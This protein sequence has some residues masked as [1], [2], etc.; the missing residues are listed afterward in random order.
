MLC[1]PLDIGFLCLEYLGQHE[2]LYRWLPIAQYLC[3]TVPR[4][5]WWHSRERFHPDMATA[6]LS[7]MTRTLQDMQRVGIPWG[8]TR[9][10]FYSVY[11]GNQTIENYLCQKYFRFSTV[12]PHF[13]FFAFAAK[14]EWSF[15]DLDTRELWT[16]FFLAESCSETIP[17]C[18]E[19]IIRAVLKLILETKTEEKLL[20]HLAGMQVVV[21][22]FLTL[23]CRRF[24]G[25]NEYS[26]QTPLHATCLI[27]QNILN[28]L[29]NLS[30]KEMF[31]Q[32][33]GYTARDCRVVQAGM[34]DLL[35]F[36]LSH[37]YLL[38]YLLDMELGN[39][40]RPLWM[41]K[42]SQWKRKT[43]VKLRDFFQS[44]FQ[45]PFY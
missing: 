44:F 27:L 2:S 16:A 20:D 11:Y 7:W 4:P 45:Q 10:L 29:T 3:Q 34:Q 25:V 43:T 15:L 22:N 14:G 32:L 40:D 28:F 37:D 8:E 39:K 9:M 1:L 38:D 26:F 33:K 12:L 31:A 24:E 30:E 13:K 42:L 21:S 19:F 41:R 5:S 18:R 6:D 17:L 36:P 35:S 23:C